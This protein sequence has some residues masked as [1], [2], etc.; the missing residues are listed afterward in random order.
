MHPCDEQEQE[1]LDIIFH[2]MSLACDGKLH[3][4]PISTNP[5][6]ILELATGTGIWAIAMGM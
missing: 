2:M 6:R 5:Q 4:A 3:L 1:R